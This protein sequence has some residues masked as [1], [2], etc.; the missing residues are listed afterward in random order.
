MEIKEQIKE[1]KSQAYDLLVSVE[2]HQKALSQVNQQIAGLSQ[3]ANAET[4][5][6]KKQGSDKQKKGKV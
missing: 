4:A 3:K 2:Q 5:K 1:L 6:S